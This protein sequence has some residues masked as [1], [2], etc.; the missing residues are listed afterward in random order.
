MR[1]KKSELLLIETIRQ[2][3]NSHTQGTVVFPSPILLKSWEEQLL[4]EL[5]WL[6][7]I[8]F[9]LFTGITEVLI[10]T[11]DSSL[12]LHAGDSQLLSWGAMQVI[13]DK[14]MEVKRHKSWQ[15]VGMTQVIA[16]IFRQLKHSGVDSNSIRKM[17]NTFP[18][19]LVEG[20]C[21]YYE[22]LVDLGLMDSE[23][24]LSEAVKLIK[25][26]KRLPGYL[27]H[28][29]VFGFDELSTAQSELVSELKKN[30]EVIFVPIS[31]TNCDEDVSSF[32]K[33]VSADRNREISGLIGCDREWEVRG[34]ARRISQYL[35]SGV[36]LKSIAVVFRNLNL[37]MPII[38]RVFKEFEIPINRDKNLPLLSHPAVK[39]FIQLL[40]T[41]ESDGSYSEMTRL[42]SL[43]FKGDEGRI[44]DSYL[45]RDYKSVCGFSL[46]QW[47]DW[48]NVIGTKVEETSKNRLDTLVKW[49]NNH[50]P[51]D[52]LSFFNM[53]W[54]WLIEFD[55]YLECQGEDSLLLWKNQSEL[56]CLWER[57][58]LL[59]KST[60]Y[61]GLKISPFE[62]RILLDSLLN[63]SNPFGSSGNIEGV[64]LSTPSEINGI[65]FERV[66]LGGLIEGDFPR[67][68]ND[69]NLVADMVF[70]QLDMIPQKQEDVLQRE[71]RLFRQVISAA[72]DELIISYPETD[73][74]GRPY[75]P[76][77][78]W[79]G[80]ENVLGG[81]LWERL[82]RKSR[83]EL[84][85]ISRREVLNIVA[86]RYSQLS[87][88]NLRERYQAEFLR[89]KGEKRY[90]GNLYG[91]KI[92]ARDLEQEFGSNYPF[93]VTALE[94]YAR[95][96]F[97]F[98][99]RRV[100]RITTQ[101]ERHN[102]LTPPNEIGILLHEVL[103]EFM[104]N[105]SGELLCSEKI[106][107][108]FQEIDCLLTNIESD[109]ESGERDGVNGLK[110]LQ[111]LQRETLRKILYYFIKDE[112]NWI[113]K[114]GGRYVPTI[115]E[116]SFTTICPSIVGENSFRL[117][118]KVDRVDIGREGDGFILFDYKSG[119][120]PTRK[121]M[122][123]G[124]DLQ[125]LVYLK[126]LEKKL[127]LKG[128]GAGYYSLVQRERTHGIWRKSWNEETGMR[129]RSLDDNEW[130]SLFQQLYEWVNQY[131]TGIRRGVF[132]PTTK[133]C[134][135]YCKYRSICRRGLTGGD[136]NEDE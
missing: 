49:L 12:I 113:K 126:A 124:L 46:S 16:D 21:R 23:T 15:A 78:Y 130:E 132:F 22:S 8:K 32:A 127:G 131:V 13:A 6:G 74:E 106:E 121:E 62:F 10:G 28:V 79:R 136:Q 104:H 97:A 89:R 29:L 30:G 47:C 52:L 96:P 58:I 76:S 90:S 109:E 41:I 105:H 57:W 39:A 110:L 120:A 59:L 93:S 20:Y 33:L 122:E 66:F 60:G 129:L 5:G 94:D 65:S 95:C 123:N 61:H 35:A 128:I 25:L 75:T 63:A 116:Q 101:D 111:R 55:D 19:P 51:Q 91:D 98:F 100:L 54:E 119:R 14:S 31:E 50:L 114:I 86:Y 125:L 82:S 103:R 17:N 115:F 26:S 18:Q 11:Q 108:Y 92:I 36:P 70:S 40:R 56:S 34:I 88:E 45:N 87:S 53:G 37:Y 107:Q 117:V 64:I 85:P 43:R 1:K 4:K 134:P 3:R 77:T 48:L 81:N 80:L 24:L 9:T 67:I 27:K 7:G 83:W 42:L 38:Q 73:A 112:I 44:I 2:W 135:K 99:C 118:G 133:E 68:S 72:K 71:R 69:N 84:S 102:S